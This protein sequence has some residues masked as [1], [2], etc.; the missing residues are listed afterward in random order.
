MLDKEIYEVEDGVLVGYHGNRDKIIIPGEIKKIDD[1]LF[2]ELDEVKSVII[3]EGVEEI[4]NYVFS[5]CHGLEKVVLPNSLIRIG[6]GAFEDCYC[7]E[8]V[9]QSQDSKLK[10][11]GK[12]AFFECE[13]LRA[14]FI[15]KSVET[16]G[17]SA[18]EGCFYSLSLFFEAKEINEL[19]MKSELYMKYMR[20]YLDCNKN[21][22]VIQDDFYF[23]LLEK[24]HSAILARYNGGKRR[25]RI[26]EKITYNDK[27]YV[28]D[29]IKSNAFNCNF[30]EYVT[31]PKSI[32][33][34][35]KN[36]FDALRSNYIINCEVDKIQEHW[37]KDF[38]P[39]GFQINFNTKDKNQFVVQN[40]FRI[41]LEEDKAKIIKYVGNEKRIN[42]PEKVTINDKTYEVIEI[43][44]DAFESCDN[45]KSIFIPRS[46]KVIEAKV[47]ASCS[48]LKSIYCEVETE[49]MGWDKEWNI[50]NVPVIW[51]Q[52]DR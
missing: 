3:E 23:N 8:R 11:I 6:E 30:L 42:V 15:P 24:Y 5:C 39:K 37:D 31:I 4:G 32:T 22:F 38:N 18:F 17:E 43:T 16:I 48:S 51:G 10:Y 35:E 33:F 9:V 29:E 13:V 49:P 12:R 47:F 34:I 44:R 36:A 41:F 45:V 52:K 27:T 7:L 1:C 2:E 28:V 25:V 20:Y 21:K 46:V 26:P 40:A 19:F 14:L 50:E